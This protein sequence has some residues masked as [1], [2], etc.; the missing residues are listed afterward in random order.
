M[1]SYIAGLYTWTSGD[2]FRCADIGILVTRLAQID[3]PLGDR[4]QVQ[5]CR[6]CV[7]AME[8][9]RRR[10]AERTGGEYMP[11]RLGRCAS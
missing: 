5:A 1:E 10:Y 9:E 8:D 11:G 6:R 7:L 3:T 2:C 4:Y